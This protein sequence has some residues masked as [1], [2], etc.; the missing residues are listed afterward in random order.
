MNICPA[1]KQSKDKKKR[2]YSKKESKRPVHKIS[3]FHSES[4]NSSDEEL[5]AKANLCMMASS[6]KDHSQAFKDNRT[7][8]KVNTSV[9]YMDSGCS[10]HMTK[11]ASLLQDIKERDGPSVTFG[12]NSK[13]KIVGKGTL[14]NGI[15]TVTN[16][17]VV[18]GLKH[19]LLSVSQLCDK[20]YSVLFPKT[21]VRL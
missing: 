7:T 20:G 13:G 9:W 11:D 15:T 19:N 6:P 21:R 12:D 1:R 18:S 3:E 14:T 4:D 5:S 2:F 17:A 16:V 8:D 10:S